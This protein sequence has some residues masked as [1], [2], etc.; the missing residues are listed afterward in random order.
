MIRSKNGY[1]VDVSKYIMI[2]D[3]YYYDDDQ[4]QNKK[5][6]NDF[7]NYYFMQYSM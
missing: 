6:R 2:D 5:I 1:F 4:N 7:R 3:D